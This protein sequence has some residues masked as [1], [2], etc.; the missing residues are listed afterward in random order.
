M[1]YI[2]LT[3]ISGRTTRKTY[4]SAGQYLDPKSGISHNIMFVKTNLLIAKTSS[5]YAV[6]FEFSKSSNSR[7]F[8][9]T[10]CGIYSIKKSVFGAVICGCATPVITADPLC[11]FYCSLI[12]ARDRLSETDPLVHDTD[13]DSP[14]R[15]TAS[16]VAHL[17]IHSPAR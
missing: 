10:V 1:P 4:S 14:R 12:A 16:Q 3:K 13:T 7:A 5:E 15:V 17:L 11:T 6:R 9:L 2:L 8:S